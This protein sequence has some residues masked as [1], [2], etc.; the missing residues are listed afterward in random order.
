MRILGA[1]AAAGAAVLLLGVAGGDTTALD[2]PA[3][4]RSPG[5]E[6]VAQ[7]AIGLAELRPPA[8]S[9]AP[10]APA[11]RHVPIPPRPEA[12]KVAPGPLGIPGSAYAAYQGA[13]DRMALEAPG[14]GVEWNLVAAIGRIESGHA[15]GGNVDAAGNTLTPIQGPVL[16]G[17][18]AGNAVIRDG[19]GFARAL[20]PMQFLTT[21]WALFGGDNSGDGKADIN[22]VRDAAY[23]AARYLCSSATGLQ[24]EAAQRVAVFAYNQ[25][26]SYVDNVVAWSKAYR[27]RAIPVGGIPD[28]AAPVAPPSTL[29]KPLPPGTVVVVGCGTPDGAPSRPGPSAAA[30]PSGPGKPSSAASSAKP[31]P[32]TTTPAR[33][34]AT[35]SGPARPSAP[36]SA[37]SAQ[38]PPDGAPLATTVTQ[39]AP[40]PPSGPSTPGAPSG[41][42]R[43]TPPGASVPA[44]PAGPGGAL[45]IPSGGPS[46]SRPAPPSASRPAA[47]SARPAPSSG[48]APSSSPTVPRPPR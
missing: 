36:S 22:N 20:G 3:D 14:C 1:T 31:G 8:P 28:M 21:T 40:P 37:S 29:P 12:V 17:S 9:D 6:L 35:P 11:A 32:A 25:S 10:A 39:C 34:F 13:A 24:A 44:G 15:D 16:D 5:P 7:A 23:G 42:P 19:E 18:L 33:P 47:P 27:D 48:P 43:P 26:N 4:H 30:A 38:R 46:T 2:A 41:P 45:A